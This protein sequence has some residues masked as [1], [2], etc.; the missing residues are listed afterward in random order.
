[1]LARLGREK[2]TYLPPRRSREPS[3]LVLSNKPDMLQ[4]MIG[5]QVPLDTILC[6]IPGSV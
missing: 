6:G 5:Y 3:Q 1:M 2:V 4:F